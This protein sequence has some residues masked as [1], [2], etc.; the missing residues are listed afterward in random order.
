[1]DSQQRLIEEAR[2]SL[3]KHTCS[4]LALAEI[5]PP[6]VVIVA[7]LAFALHPMQL[8]GAG[9][10]DFQT[11]AKDNLRHL[12]GGRHVHKLA[13]VGLGR[14]GGAC[15][16]DGHARRLHHANRF[17]VPKHSHSVNLHVLG[18]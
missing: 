8:K 14:T 3:H 4:L 13:A 6:I 18:A 16:H 15:K 2:R 5:I 17:R 1:M 11:R 12:L 9:N 7:V 10:R